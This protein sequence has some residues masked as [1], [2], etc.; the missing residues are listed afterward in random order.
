M[1]KA[2]LVYIIDPDTNEVLMAKK[3]KK[4]GIGYWFGYG[5]KTEEGETL[6]DCVCRETNEES[7]GVITL[8][9][10]NLEPVVRMKFFNKKELNPHIDDPVFEV[11][12]YRIFQKKSEVGTPLSTEEMA[13]PTWFPVGN[14]PWNEMKPGDELFVPHILSGTLME[15]WLWFDQGEVLGSD[16]KSCTIEDISK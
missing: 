2:T 15:G 11:L 8:K 3:M 6:E 4:V 12:C 1:S 7:G 14:I 16:I 10:E 13:D 9:K 5:G